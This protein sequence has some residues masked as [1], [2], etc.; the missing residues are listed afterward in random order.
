MDIGTAKP[1]LDEREGIPHHL[2]DICDPAEHFSVSNFL[3]RANGLIFDIQSRGKLPLLVGGTMLYFKTLL[4]GLANLPDRDEAIRKKIETQA[5]EEGWPKLYEALKKVDEII[6]NKIS[7]QDSQRIQ[8]ALEVYQ[9]TGVPMSLLLEKA[10]QS[11]LKF[12]LLALFPS[13]RAWLHQRI[14]QRFERMMVQGFLK[15]MQVFVDRG[16]L[17]LDMSSMRCV[18]YR[19]AWE[20]IQGQ[21]CYDAFMQKSLAATRQLAKRQLTWLRNWKGEI[22]YFDPLEGGLEEK[23][24]KA[25]AD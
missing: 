23:V 5:N 13:D 11:Q 9:L 15:E 22:Q 3:D 1:S 12:K 10:K 25:I 16:D 20:Y 7:P 24:L 8:R 19:Q 14:E 18:G 4:D 2:I 6:A 17:S 21:I